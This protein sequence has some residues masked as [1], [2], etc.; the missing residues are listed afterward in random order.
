MTTIIQR[1]IEEH[2]RTGLSQSETWEGAD[3]GLI[4]CWEVGR[5]RAEK[6]PEL[7]A[8]C[9]RGE[10]PTL[11]WK[12]GVSRAL[13]KLEKF[14]TLKYLAQWQG[15]RGENLDIEL[16]REKTLTCTK[17]GMIVTFTPDQSKYI[18]QI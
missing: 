2:L 10:L 16:T 5:T 14:G 17:T 9:L 12:G 6:N 15:L 1:Q 13:V 8:Q 3:K 7:A 11:G 4:K 18:N